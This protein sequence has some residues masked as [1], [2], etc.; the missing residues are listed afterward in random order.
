MEGAS[1]LVDPKASNLWFSQGRC[2]IDSRIALGSFLCWMFET[3][4]IWKKTLIGIFVR[5]NE[6]AES[7]VSSS[8]TVTTL[9]MVIWTFMV[10]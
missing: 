8:S 7:I 9:G 4:G 2:L 6:M 1:P 3:L 10:V 5:I